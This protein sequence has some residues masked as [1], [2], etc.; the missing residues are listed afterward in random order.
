M[1]KYI[2]F[3][4]PKDKYGFASNFYK[5]KP[6]KIDGEIWQNTEQYFQAMKF[7]GPN[8]SERSIKYSDLIKEADSPM[9]FK[10]LGT[11]KKNLRWGKKWKLNKKTDYRLVNDLVD[12]YKDV[13]LRS[14]WD[15]ARL[16]VMVKAL[17]YKFKDPIL[18]AKI[19]AIPDN[20]LMVEHTTR[21][22]VWGDGG[23]GGTGE[24]GTNYLGKILTAI[25][26]VLKYGNCNKMSQ[27][28]REKIRIGKLES[29][30]F[31]YLM[32]EIRKIIA[33]PKVDLNVFTTKDLGKALGR[34][35]KKLKILF[36]IYKRE[37]LKILAVK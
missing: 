6:L 28:I 33:D 25:S 21:D 30:K 34:K 37:S 8:A 35:N 27:K 4:N 10:I 13:K 3:Y 15:M 2:L 12:D 19:I 22:K 17:L 14:D 26:Y 31:N 11:Q 7:R 24:K 20:A 1:V 29:K 36:R 9:K 23:D 16:L 5:T 32:Q 18:R